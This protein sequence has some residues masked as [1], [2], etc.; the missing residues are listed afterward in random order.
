MIKNP[1]IPFSE[2]KKQLPEIEEI[3][4][5]T[6][7][8]KN[9]YKYLEI[10]AVTLRSYR[11]LVPELDIVI[12]ESSP[13]VLFEKKLKNKEVLQKIENI[14]LT[15]CKKDVAEYLKIHPA[16]LVK[17]SREYP[18]LELAIN[19]GLKNHKKMEVI[20]YDRKLS[21]DIIEYNLFPIERI[22]EET[23]SLINVANYLNICRDTLS[24]YRKLHK[25]LDTV[26]KQGFK[27]YQLSGDKIFNDEDLVNIE[28]I[29][30]NGFRKDVAKY[31]GICSDTL[32]TYSKTY[33][34]LAEAIKRGESFRSS[35]FWKKSY[36]NKLVGKD[37][38][39]KQKPFIPQ[40]TQ[41]EKPKKELVASTEIVED[42]SE[43]ALAVY[44]KKKE[45]EREDS[46]QRR[47]QSMSEFE[48][49]I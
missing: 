34:Q 42:I 18:A 39:K 30:K 49:M 10:D 4:R 5:N 14:L 16:L 43:D 38:V 7:M 11:K 17:Y 27:K 28:K 23:G 36:Y 40:Q 15:G 13:V 45:V 32:R 35:D 22:A 31:L 8:I 25:G 37:L 6:G 24:Q 20:R 9:V 33:P 41:L 48:Y 21:L 46:L 1:K 44:R 2:I 47:V 3:L 19:N 29:L 12:R 26:I